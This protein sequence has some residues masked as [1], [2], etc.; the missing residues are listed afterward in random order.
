MRFFDWLTQFKI[1]S[2]IFVVFFVMFIV[3]FGFC[4]A[5]IWTS[6]ERVGGLAALF[7]ITSLFGSFI[8]AAVRDIAG[9]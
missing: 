4:A 6:D 7:L 1:T 2:I 3:G 5:A 8:T 9:I